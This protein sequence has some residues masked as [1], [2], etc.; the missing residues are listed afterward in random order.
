MTAMLPVASPLALLPDFGSGEM[1]L[2]L[3]AVLLLFGGEKMPQLAKALGRS[4]REFKKAANEVER[5][6]KKA[7]DEVPDQPDLKSTWQQVL[8]DN[9]KPAATK[10]AGTPALPAPPAAAVVP[11]APA[12]STPAGYAPSEAAPYTAGAVPPPATV[13]PPPPDV[14]ENLPGTGTPPPA[15]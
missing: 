7:I 6:I 14:Q 9:P 10:P 11:P 13:A 15:P 5:E 1:M 3:L 8:E 12:P 2:V 4:I